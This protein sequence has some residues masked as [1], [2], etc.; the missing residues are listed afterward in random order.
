[1]TKTSSVQTEHVA[2]TPTTLNNVDKHKKTKCFKKLK[3]DE[4]KKFWPFSDHENFL[5]DYHSQIRELYKI[6]EEYLNERKGNDVYG[7]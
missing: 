2:A 1:M 6:E 7:A 3:P 4:K 5:I